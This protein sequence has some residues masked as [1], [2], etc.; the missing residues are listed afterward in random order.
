MSLFNFFMPCED[1]L[2]KTSVV[3][4]NRFPI[5]IKG[6][7]SLAIALFVLT[8][9]IA[10]KGK[11]TSAFVMGLLTLFCVFS[12]ISLRKGKLTNYSIFL[13]LAIL[14]SEIV[15][16]YTLFNISM[17]D[18]MII[19]RLNVMFIT[20]A[21]YNSILLVSQKQNII[22]CLL[23]FLNWLVSMCV[24]FS[25]MYITNPSDTVFAVSCCSL[26]FLVSIFTSIISFS[27]I[28]KIVAIFKREQDISQ[29]SLNTLSNALTET[30]LSLDVGKELLVGVKRAT[31][32]IESV[33]SLYS[34]LT[35]ESSTLGDEATSLVTGINDVILKSQKM[36]DSVL[37]QNSSITQTS[38]AMSEISA[39]LSNVSSVAAKRQ[40]SINEMTRIF[41]KQR[42]DLI[43]LTNQVQEVQQ[44][45]KVIS[46]FVDTVNDIAS[47]TGL[48]AMNASIEAA[49]AGS[50]G[51]GFSVIA[52]EIRKLSDQTTKNASQIDEQLKK[53]FEIVQ[54][55]QNSVLAFSDLNAKSAS[56]LSST[57]Q[58]FEE[59]ISGVNEMN[60][61]TQEVSTALQ[62]IVD[63][64]H[65][66]ADLVDQVSDELG[67][68]GGAV[69]HV[70]DFATTLKDRIKTLDTMILEIRTVLMEIEKSAQKN[71]EIASSLNEVLS[72]NE[73]TNK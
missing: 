6:V 5:I 30:N 70:S 12:L 39:N 46:G 62:T 37:S 4:R 40:S 18:P 50:M 66:S 22:F 47:Q 17:S 34:Y 31:G 41:E 65:N 45:S 38:A 71:E 11:V 72:K 29:D 25:Q 33:A 23:S 59:I 68:Q 63:E 26:A 52:Q 48:L 20:L 61:G 54:K 73:K 1:E 51:K 36:K 10:T 60:L 15:S 2:K 9:F 16:T 19:Y 43:A 7:F 49:H 3:N 13:L 69:S 56:E 8:A 57:V 35:K 32:S 42:T 14:G 44:S 53:N 55:A 28:N 67:T 27:F 64:T 21:L 24:C 58:S